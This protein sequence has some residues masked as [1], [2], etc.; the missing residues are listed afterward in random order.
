[1][2]HTFGNV[3][4]CD[5]PTV[6]QEI[7]FHKNIK[8]KTVT[9]EGRFFLDSLDFKSMDWS[10]CICTYIFLYTHFKCFDIKNT[11]QAKRDISTTYAI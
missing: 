1:M 8:T 4:L 2:E 10:V 3:I 6:A 11:E 5:N 9:Y 7:A